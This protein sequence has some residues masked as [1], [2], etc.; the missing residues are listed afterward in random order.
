LWRVGFI[1]DEDRAP[2][3]DLVARAQEHIALQFDAVQARAIGG[4]QVHQPV[5]FTY[6]L[7]A[8]VLAAGLLVC[9][10]ND[11]GGGTAHGGQVVHQVVDALLA[12]MAYDLQ[13]NHLASAE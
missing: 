12:I 13:L 10:L 8:E 5:S 11:A 2:Q 4:P 7:D 1:E 3:P 9:D 6:L